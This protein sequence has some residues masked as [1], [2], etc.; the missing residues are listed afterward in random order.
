[1]PLLFPAKD[2]ERPWHPSIGW[3]A[4]GKRAAPYINTGKAARNRTALPADIRICVRN[5][6]SGEGTE[7][8]G[9]GLD[10]TACTDA[11]KDN[12]MQCTVHVLLIHLHGVSEG[13]SGN[14]G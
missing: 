8:P 4:H 13:I 5:G 7:E 14:A 3:C 1:M 9:I 2:A 12:Q 6:K 10:N 11:V